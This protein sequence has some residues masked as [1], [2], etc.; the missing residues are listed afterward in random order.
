MLRVQ[1]SFP[2][3][4]GGFDAHHIYL[5]LPWCLR[6]IRHTHPESWSRQIID[7]HRAS[8]V[9]SVT[10]STDSILDFA[11][12]Q[13]EVLWNLRDSAVGLI[14]SAGGLAAI[15]A[16]FTA[17]VR[18][19][20]M[21]VYLLPVALT[22]G[23]CGLTMTSA[24]LVVRHAAEDFAPEWSYICQMVAVGL[25]IISMIVFITEKYTGT[26]YDEYGVRVVLRPAAPSVI[27]LLG[28]LVCGLV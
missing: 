12:P 22:T 14:F 25:L 3:S 20:H 17:I 8:V 5:L 9:T 15:C 11:T 10:S 26:P 27:R 21:V 6:S 4:D 1:P 13:N 28:G 16:L 7:G 2:R 24:F 23:A 18:T 19:A